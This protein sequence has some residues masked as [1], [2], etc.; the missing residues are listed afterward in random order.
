MEQEPDPVSIYSKD[1]SDEDHNQQRREMIYDLYLRLSLMPSVG[2]WSSCTDIDEHIRT[3]AMELFEIIG[4]LYLFGEPYETNRLFLVQVLSKF[5]KQFYID[6]L[7]ELHCLPS[8][9][10][11]SHF[12]DEYLEPMAQGMI[13]VELT[14]ST[15]E[16]R[17]LTPC[18]KSTSQTELLQSCQDCST[19][20]EEMKV[21]KAVHQPKK[22]NKRNDQTTFPKTETTTILH[23]SNHNQRCE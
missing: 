15:A 12:W 23:H 20:D 5:P 19:K 4:E 3:T 16:S 22:T 6:K 7:K 11:F 18:T 1:P 8:H 14:S 13:P 10:R 2:K 17:E 9:M 21:L